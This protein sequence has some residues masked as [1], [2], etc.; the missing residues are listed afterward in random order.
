MP[1]MSAIYNYDCK[2]VSKLS[3]LFH[4]DCKF[5]P[6]LSAVFIRAI[7]LCRGYRPFSLCHPWLYGSAGAIGLI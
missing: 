7:G 4:Y 1:E 6:E 5:V 3:A 2:S